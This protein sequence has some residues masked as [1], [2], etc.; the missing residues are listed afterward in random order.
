MLELTGPRVNA[1]NAYRYRQLDLDV[2]V[3]AKTSTLIAKALEDGS[4][5]TRKEL[6]AI[7]E[8]GGV[9]S[10]G[11]RL[12]YILMRA[13]L[14]G[15]VCSGA[16]RGKQHTYASLG[17]RAPLARTLDREAALAELTRRY[18]TS[19]GPATLKDYVRWSS[20]T[21]AEGRSG[22]DAVKPEL[23]YEVVDDRTYWFAESPRK[24][25]TS[26]KAIDLVQG[27]DE[28][29][30]SYS[31]SRDVLVGPLGADEAARIAIVFVHMVLRDG[32][33]MGHWR[34]ASR[35]KSIAIEA[36][37][38]KRLN[39]VEEKAL[40]AAVERYGRF[41]GVSASYSTFL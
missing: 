1:L 16:R 17:K 4:Q 7:L 15:V 29:I 35:G 14:D 34:P 40:K 32:Q 37:F 23:E 38:Y 13:E 41:L 22:L 26:S 25:K 18:F 24:A 9:K 3:L 12:A 27:L 20:L 5:R 8:R 6:A 36:S 31:E 10:D 39:R 19:R 11:Q 33:F 2:P 28:Y 21:M 30:M